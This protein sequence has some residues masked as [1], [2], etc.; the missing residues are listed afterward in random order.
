MDGIMAG[1]QQNDGLAD[2]DVNRQKVS[3]AKQNL[4]RPDLIDVE[5]V[6]K[7]Y[8]PE[9]FDSQEMFI[10]DMRQNYQNDV[11]FDRINRYEFYEKSKHP[12]DTKQ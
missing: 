10:K 7:S 5:P 1:F 8:V 2:I 11:D 6:K 12:L 9:G 4:R 3:K